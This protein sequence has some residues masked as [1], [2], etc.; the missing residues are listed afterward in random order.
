MYLLENEHQLEDKDWLRM[1]S[2]QD[3][4]V[5]APSMIA[6]ESDR[7]TVYKTHALPKCC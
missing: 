5:E 7:D 3:R 6:L 4:G 1:E 2:E